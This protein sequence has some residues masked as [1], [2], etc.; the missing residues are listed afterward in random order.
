MAA[1]ERRDAA[2]EAQLVKLEATVE[3]RLGG[4]KKG[5]EALHGRLQAMETAMSKLPEHLARFNKKIKEHGKVGRGDRTYNAPVCTCAAHAPGARCSQ[6]AGQH[7]TLLRELQHQ[8]PALADAADH[9]RGRV[10]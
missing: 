10:K 7:S 5:M 8:L 6:V 4:V 9:C 2:R 1:L 3:K